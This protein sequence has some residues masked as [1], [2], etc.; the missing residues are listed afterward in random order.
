MKPLLA[1]ILLS[2]TGCKEPAPAK[3]EPSLTPPPPVQKGPDW[4]SAFKH[5]IKLDRGKKSLLVDVKVAPGYHA[6]TVGESIGKPL[7]ITVDEDSAWSLAGEVQY[8]KGE[9]KDLPVGK[10]VIVEGEAQIV[11]PVEKKADGKAK[12][13]F[14]YQVCTDE[15]CDRPRTVT[16]ELPG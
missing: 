12:G 10:S 8:P 1:L 13:K 2:V 9:E 14:R 6:Y 4:K 11:A 3:L 5:E 15:A 7:K 16:F